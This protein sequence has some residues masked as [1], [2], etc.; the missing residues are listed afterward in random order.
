MNLTDTDL[1]PPTRTTEEVEEHL[2]QM[3]RD[4]PKDV[5]PKERERLRAEAYLLYKAGRSPGQIAKLF[6]NAVTARMV[7]RWAKEKNWTRRAMV[8]L[9]EAGAPGE[10]VARIG[11]ADLD[12][13]TLALAVR[14]SERLAEIE[15]QLREIQLLAA[16]ERAEEY[17][18]QMAA[19]GCKLIITL[20]EWPTEKL[21]ANYEAVVKLDQMFRQAL[22]LAPQASGG[23][24]GSPPS[25][26][27]R[28]ETQAPL[29][30]VQMNGLSGAAPPPPPAAG[31]PP[32]QV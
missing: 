20:N 14:R 31:S 21:I 28:R 32:I 3:D 26:S 15:V 9:I 6:N 22:C 19:L 7:E 11:G 1:K 17:A 23:S 30:A 5:D 12:Q 2:E 29:V 27:G 24:G 4:K 16:E 25:R 13:A 8:E 10:Q 18:K